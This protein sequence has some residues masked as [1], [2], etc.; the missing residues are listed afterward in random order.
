MQPLTKS[1]SKVSYLN[2][3]PLGSD[4]PTLLLFAPH[5]AEKSPRNKEVLG[6]EKQMLVTIFKVNS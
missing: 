2:P 3:V 6:L 4:L 5:G 1:V